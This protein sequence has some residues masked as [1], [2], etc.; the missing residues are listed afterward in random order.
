MKKTRLLLLLTV[1]LYLPFAV[2]A[3]TDS[4]A[5]DSLKILA[6]RVES[7]NKKQ[8]TLMAL[9]KAEADTA[10]AQ[11]I[12]ASDA[13]IKNPLPNYAHPYPAHKVA[14]WI[15]WL[16]LIGFLVM[17]FYFFINSPLCRDESY[18]PDGKPKEPKK[19][20][21]S[22]S[23]V[24]LFWWTVIIISCFTWF[25]AQF[26]VLL[27]FNQTVIL[28]LT[29]GIVVRLFG[30]TIDN[31]QIRK[32]KIRASEAGNNGK[33]LSTRHQ[34]VHDSKG[35][36]TDILSDEDGVSM[37]RMQ[38][39]MFNLVYGVAFISYFFSALK[40][41]QYPFMEFE[42]WQL[43]LLGISSA[44]YLTLKTMENSEETRENRREE[45]VENMNT[46][47]NEKINSQIEEQRLNNPP[48][49]NNTNTNNSN[50]GNQQQ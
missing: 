40:N 42:D 3:Q 34:D 29:G 47:R 39:V 44:G 37:H 23:K 9:L 7:L 46:F 15:S 11:S 25:F 13:F 43:A 12:R 24:Q 6:K 30:K 21:F 2:S 36:L 38:A 1:M 19:R 16:I 5:R 20:P 17:A 22:F 45:A 10:A 27:P 4:T 33:P 8:D 50:T 32:N 14:S 35:F 26:G 31:T 49:N 18:D 41:R 28:L 48:I